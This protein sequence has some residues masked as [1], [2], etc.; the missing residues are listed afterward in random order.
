MKVTVIGYWGAFPNKDEATSGYLINSGNY[1]ILVDCGSGVLSKLQSYTDLWKIDAVILSHYHS[2]HIADIFCF[3]YEASLSLKLGIRKKPLEIYAHNLDPKFNDLNYKGGTVAKKIDD[4]TIL[5]FG[6]LN[7]SFKWTKHAVPCLAM[8]FQEGEKVIAYSGDTEWCNEIIDIS[9]ESDLFI[10]ETSIYNNLKGKID[11]H[12][13]AGEVGK[14][15]NM[16]KVNKLV[17]SHFPH[18]GNS[19]DLVNEAK[20]EFSGEIYK[21]K[22]GLTF[23]L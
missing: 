10:C 11:G 7:I 4:K 13:T 19:D 23:Q 6:D 1:N 12:L 8:R 2:D 22:T 18:Y 20:E 5:T 3:Q 17:L 9:R 16:S 21:A 15:A 14:I